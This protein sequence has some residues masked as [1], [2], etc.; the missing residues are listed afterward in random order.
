MILLGQVS[1][2]ERFNA[3]VRQSYKRQYNDETH[4]H[5]KICYDRLCGRTVC[6]TE[7]VNGSAVGACSRSS[8]HFTDHVRTGLLKRVFLPGTGRILTPTLKQ[9]LCMPTPSCNISSRT[10]RLLIF[11]LRVTKPSCLPLCRPHIPPKE[12]ATCAGPSQLLQPIAGRQRTHACINYPMDVY[13]LTYLTDCVGQSIDF[14]LTQ[15]HNAPKQLMGA[16]QTFSPQIL[17]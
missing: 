4:R 14:E 12:F 8:P 17:T 10:W 15:P 11:L 3:P 7:D 6:I 16:K 1:R 5:L 2:H 13:H 9:L